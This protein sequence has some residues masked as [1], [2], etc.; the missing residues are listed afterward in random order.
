[1]VDIEGGI[2]GLGGREVEKGMYYCGVGVHPRRLR[3]LA[4]RHLEYCLYAGLKIAGLNAEVS[5]S[6]WEFQIG[7]AEGI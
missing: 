1:M 4:E 7:I 6:Q 2:V 5:V 3:E